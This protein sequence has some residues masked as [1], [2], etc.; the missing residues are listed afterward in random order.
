MLSC[1]TE[2]A[3]ETPGK[4]EASAGPSSYLPACLRG[5]EHTGHCDGWPSRGSPITVGTSTTS[6]WGLA[7]A[8]LFGITGL[9]REETL[10]HITLNIFPDPLCPFPE[11]YIHCET[12][13]QRA[14]CQLTAYD[15]LISRERERTGPVSSSRPWSLP[16]HRPRPPR[17]L[18]DP[19]GLLGSLLPCL[20]L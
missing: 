8:Q 19:G 13:T 2:S 5:S 3:Q 6:F 14:V 9:R 4:T 17:R 16:D 1:V 20:F 11:T 12:D 7:K 10:Y 15:K 18:H